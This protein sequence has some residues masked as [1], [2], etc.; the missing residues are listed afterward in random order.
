MGRNHL[1]AIH[2]IFW[3]SQTS[4][5]GRALK[6]SVIICIEFNGIL[7]VYSELHANILNPWTILLRD[8]Y[9]ENGSCCGY[10]CLCV[11]LFVSTGTSHKRVMSQFD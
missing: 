4:Y 11:G 8:Q 2:I 10:A 3:S 6:E 1:S 7:F 9:L 5:N